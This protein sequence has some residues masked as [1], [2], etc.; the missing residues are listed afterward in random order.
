[1]PKTCVRLKTAIK[2][3]TVDGLK[4]GGLYGRKRV[5]R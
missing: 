3:L 2:E 1:M 5:N 4:T